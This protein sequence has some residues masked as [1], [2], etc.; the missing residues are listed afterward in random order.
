MYVEYHVAGGVTYIDVGVRVGVV[1]YP[2][3]VGVRFICTFC[4]LRG[5]GTMGGEHGWVDHDGIIEERPHYLL[6]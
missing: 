6:H 3:G 2:E 1:D 4:L 5:D